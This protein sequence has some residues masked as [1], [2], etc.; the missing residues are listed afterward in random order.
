M[1]ATT[2]APAAVRSTS[3]DGPE[4]L[5][6]EGSSGDFAGSDGPPTPAVTGTATAAVALAAAAT[7]TAS[8]L[9]G[10]IKR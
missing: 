10:A 3:R 4:R 8:A 9:T 5:H 6:R 7:E 2:S 1:T